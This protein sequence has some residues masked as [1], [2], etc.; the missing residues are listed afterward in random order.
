MD[1]TL[2]RKGL[3]RLAW[4]ISLAF[5]GP[6]VIYQAFKNQDHPFY[7]PVLTIGVLICVFCI[8]FG[9]LGIR[10]LTDAL[11]GQKRSTKTSSSDQADKY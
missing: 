8:G 9:F 6:V 7:I 10:T 2:L 3:R 11:L 5:I 4:F 1:T